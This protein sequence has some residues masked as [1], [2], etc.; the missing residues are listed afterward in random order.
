MKDQLFLL[1]PGFFNDGQG[2]FYCGDSV[3]V[4]GLLSFAPELRDKVEVHYIAFERP[5]APLVDALG[6]LHQGAPVLILS[7]AASPPQDLPV[8]Q[9]K[10]R[11][12]IADEGAIRRYL[13][14]AYG[15]PSAS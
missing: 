8:H 13:S 11:R 1:Q 4:E 9:A 2:P 7:D 15:A 10:G 3:A 5:R 6:P 14:L 12:F